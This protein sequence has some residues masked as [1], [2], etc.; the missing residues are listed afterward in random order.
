MPQGKQEGLAAYMGW[1]QGT[2]NLKKSKRIHQEP[3][4]SIFQVL[5]G[6][7]NVDMST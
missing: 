1:Y 6:L 2:M 5:E 3:T 7:R 4:I